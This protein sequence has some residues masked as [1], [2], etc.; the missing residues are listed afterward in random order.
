MNDS[1]RFEKIIPQ[2][3]V[4]DVVKTAEYYRD[5]LGFTILD[6]FLDPPVYSR[7]E[8]NGVEI[9]FGKA[10][11]DEISVNESV[12]KGLGNDAYIIVSDIQKL[13]EEFVERDV[14]IIEGPIKRV[15][16]SIE[17]IIEDCNG[18][19]LAFGD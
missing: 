8:R 9:H 13:H 18:F 15:Y 14:E 17:I 19:K 3:V 1:V 16:G 2:F 7:V 11:G 5:V 4:H 12:R 6:Y 10:D